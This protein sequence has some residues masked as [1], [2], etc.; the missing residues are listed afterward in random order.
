MITCKYYPQ[1]V[2]HAKCVSSCASLVSICTG[3]QSENSVLMHDDDTLS[4]CRCQEKRMLNCRG[5]GWW[6]APFGGVGVSSHIPTDTL[7]H[8]LKGFT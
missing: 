3:Y 5:G 2:K 1:P 8:I 6:V 4:E 7:H